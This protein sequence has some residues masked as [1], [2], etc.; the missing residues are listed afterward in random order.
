MSARPSRRRLGRALL[1]M[2]AVLALV[3][4]GTVARAEPV[5]PPQ[6]PPASRSPRARGRRPTSSPAIRRRYRRRPAVRRG[7]RGA[8]P[9]ALR[10]ATERA[11]EREDRRA[12]LRRRA[13]QQHRRD[14]A[15]P[16][17]QPPAG[18]VLRHRYQRERPTGHGAVDRGGWLPAGQP[19]L[20]APRH[21]PP[22]RGAAGRR[23]G[24]REQPAGEHRRQS[25]L[26]LPPAVRGVQQHD[27]GP[28]PGPQ[29]G[30][31]QL[32]GRHPRLGGARLGGPLLD[33]P[34]HRPGRA[35]RHPDPSGDPLHNQP[36]GNPATV[37][38]LPSIIAF[39]RDRGYTVVDLAGN[40]DPVDPTRADISPVG[41]PRSAFWLAHCWPSC[42]A[43]TARCTCPPRP[44]RVSGPS[45]E[46]PPAR[47]A[48]RRPSAGTGSGSTSSSPAPTEP[49]GT[50]PRP[51][52][53]KGSPRRSSRGS[54]S[55]AR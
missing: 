11:G 7:G 28:G 13:R 33:R 46:S 39:Y 44:P 3:T 14:P 45:G 54:T 18:D 30:G 27:A 47:A 50:P 35:G 43:P 37:A 53:V 22:D 42:G 40:V 5:P 20:V 9:G 29:H 34:D 36:G 1:V 6:P 32:V 38:A 51:S 41:W 24:R 23:D 48:V 4:V 52:T 15:D 8:P 31:L 10:R 55:A 49:C 25:A 21:V 12:H 19:Q 2:T 17:G 26:L 16:H